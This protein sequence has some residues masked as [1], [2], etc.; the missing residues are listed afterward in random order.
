MMFYSKKYD[1]VCWFLVS[2]NVCQ[3]QVA[4]KVSLQQHIDLVAVKANAKEAVH[5]N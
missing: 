3:G 2:I 1:Y 5:S 4:T